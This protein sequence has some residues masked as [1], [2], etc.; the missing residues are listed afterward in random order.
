[1]RLARRGARVVLIDSHPFPRA[2]PCGEYLNLGAIRELYDLGLGDELASKAARLEGMRLFVHDELASFPISPP[3]WS[4]ARLR[5]DTTLRTA[6]LAAGAEPALGRLQR[7]EAHGNGVTL[8]LSERD[9]GS[10]L[11]DAGY[12]VGADGMRSTVARLCDL[13]KPVQNGFFAIVGHHPNMP[14]NKWIEI[15]TT[16]S[17]YLAFNPLDAQSANV[18]F[19]LHRND[20]AGSGGTLQSVLRSFSERVTHG[21]RVVDDAQFHAQRRAIGPLAHRAVRPFSSVCC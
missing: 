2:K 19:V 13:S 3:A 12:V 6:A 11:I 18:V 21:R 20:L 14:L 9:G 15:Y 16:S 10:L 4:I 7:L 8:C 5:L 1:M 17:G